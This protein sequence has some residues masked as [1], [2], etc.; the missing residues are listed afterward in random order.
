MSRGPPSD[1][2]RRRRQDLPSISSTYGDSSMAESSRNPN[3]VF[4][5]E[6]DCDVSFDCDDCD[7]APGVSH[8]SARLTRSGHRESSAPTTVR[9]N[10]ERGSASPYARPQ[11]HQSVRPAVGRGGPPQNVSQQRPEPRANDRIDAADPGRPRPPPPT[12]PPQSPRH[13]PPQLV[14][15]P[16][17]SGPV[18]PQ[19][20]PPPPPPHQ[21]PRMSEGPQLFFVCSV[22]KT[23]RN[24]QENFT[25]RGGYVR[26]DERG[27][28]CA[29]G[30][31]CAICFQT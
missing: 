29:Y 24:V 18:P 23:H 27:P 4:N 12:V 31:T 3:T 8:Q 28:R 14:H 9:T 5:V 30:R 20:Q 13:P 10:T 22:R 1:S 19:P 6:Y 2:N 17:P 11:Q 7:E 21:E 25:R 26:S 15:P 16:A